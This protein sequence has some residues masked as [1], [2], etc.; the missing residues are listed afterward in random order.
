VA[1]GMVGVRDRGAGDARPRSGREPSVAG[2]TTA[3]PLN[4]TLP[5][6]LDSFRSAE[7]EVKGT[8]GYVSLNAD[9]RGP[10]HVPAVQKS[11]SIQTLLCRVHPAIAR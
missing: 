4:A 5:L 1:L 7:A 3:T 8:T 6:A 9:R 10:W 2:R 11:L